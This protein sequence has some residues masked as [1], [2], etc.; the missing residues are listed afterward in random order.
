MSDQIVLDSSLGKMRG[1]VDI[2]CEGWPGPKRFVLWSLEKG[3]RMSEAIKDAAA[4]YSRL[5][6]GM[7]MYAFTGRLPSGVESG[8]AI[9][10]RDGEG[11][12]LLFEA[13]WMAERFVAIGG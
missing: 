10:L 6:G 12:I 3:Q 13:D 8:I 1:L 2:Q 4:E 7:P 5:F 11:E 9:P